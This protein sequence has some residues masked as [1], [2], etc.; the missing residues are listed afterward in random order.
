MDMDKRWE[1]RVKRVKETVKAKRRKS[2]EELYKLEYE[3]EKEDIIYDREF[4]MLLGYMIAK[5]N[6]ANTPRGKV[7]L[8]YQCYSDEAIKKVRDYL[9]E[10]TESQYFRGNIHVRISEVGIRYTEEEIKEHEEYKKRAKAVLYSAFAGFELPEDLGA[11]IDLLNT[12]D[13]RFKGELI[14]FVKDVHEAKGKDGMI[15]DG[16]IILE[17]KTKEVFPFS[18]AECKTASGTMTFRKL[19]EYLKDLTARNHDVLFDLVE[20]QIMDR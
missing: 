11:Y 17:M 1:E 3:R 19:E 4:W 18:K 6:C 10:E 2:P 13:I 5:E 9:K 20:T 7:Y 16:T 8:D 15:S 12:K 14:R